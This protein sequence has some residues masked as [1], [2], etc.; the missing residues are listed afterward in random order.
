MEALLKFIYEQWAVLMTAPAAFV[1]ALA[2]GAVIGWA[3]A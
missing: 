1:A 2:L 3:A